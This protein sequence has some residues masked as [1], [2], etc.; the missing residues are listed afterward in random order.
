M[1]L[2]QFDLLVIRDPPEPDFAINAAGCQIAA[3][4]AE[5]YRHDRFEGLAEARSSEIGAMKV[6]L[7]QLD[8]GQIR[9]P[10]VQIREVVAA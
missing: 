9:L 10:D 6:D 1:A 4:G 8:I 7:R 5:R 3:I 2:E